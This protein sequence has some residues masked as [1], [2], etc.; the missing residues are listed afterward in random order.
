MKCNSKRKIRVAFCHIYLSPYRIGFFEELSKSS[1]LDIDFFIGALK[2]KEITWGVGLENITRNIKFKCHVL[3]SLKFKGRLIAFNPSLLF[4]LIKGKYHVF[5]S[6]ALEFPGTYIAFIC[7]RILRKPFI[8]WFGETC[9]SYRANLKRSFLYRLFRLYVLK[10]IIKWILTSSSAFI[11]YGMEQ[12]KHLISLGA[13]ANKIRIALNAHD[14]SFITNVNINELS[15]LQEK[16]KAFLREKCDYPK[17]II[18]YTGSLVSSKKLDVLLKAFA[19]LS[20]E[21]GDCSLLLIG[22]GPYKSDLLELAKQLGV[23]S[24]VRF[25]DAIERKELVVF[26]SLCDLFVLPGPGGV[27]LIEA[28]YAG[29]PVIA[30]HECDNA[31]ILIRNGVNGY[32]VP[33]GDVYKLYLAMRNILLKD[34]GTLKEMGHRSREIV[35][36]MCSIDKMVKVFENVILNSVKEREV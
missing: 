29:K 1:I 33:P 13:P 14:V 7:S 10:P 24:K 35:Q 6:G 28:M 20:K 2:P 21:M 12:Q 31:H 19:L 16:Y 22:S 15:F 34:Q 32:L 8:L 26:Y 9:E 27:A 30:T 5:L 4:R 36:Q 18:L 17:K 3:F 11:V 25:L 23:S